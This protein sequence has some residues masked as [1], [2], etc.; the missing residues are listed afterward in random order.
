MIPVV[1]DSDVGI[2]DAV[3]LWWLALRDDVE[4]MGVTTV[5][6]NV[7][8]ADAA[9]NACRVLELAGRSEVPVA[10]GAANPFGHVPELRRADF[11]HGA[12]GVADTGRAPVACVPS[13]E[14][15]VDLLSR[16]VG[17]RPGEVVVVTIGPLTNIADVITNDP[18]W[19]TG[20]A[21]LVVM[22]GVVGDPGNA[23]PVAEANIA[24]DPVAAAVVF[25]A[26][27]SQPPLLVGLDVTHRATLTTE[28]ISLAREGRTTAAV[29]L[30]ELLAFYERFGG[31]FC[32]PGEFPCHDALAAMA[33]VLP[34]I[35]GGPVLPLG[36]QTE[37]GPA[38]GM[39]V[40]DR[41]QPFFEA[42]G[43]F[44]SSPEGFGRCQIG[45]E[46]DVERFRREIRSLLGG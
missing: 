20:V 30:A 11:I 19:S 15:A 6:G 5:F 4:L 31:T 14:A 27:W 9:R 28:D 41:R 2:D 23:L 26:R 24:H 36:V 32:A 18:E 25:G 12:D 22:G 29:D 39:T 42:A 3:A 16:V 37:P 34:D 38:W 17:E 35:V 7:D 40:V 21:R 44:Q 10:C 33:A 43:Q 13:N 45:L 8:I 46:V 1:V